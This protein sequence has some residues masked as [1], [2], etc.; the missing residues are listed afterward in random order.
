MGKHLSTFHVCGPRF[1]P[2]T[3]KIKYTYK[4]KK[5]RWHRVHCK[6]NILVK[7]CRLWWAPMILGEEQVN[8]GQ[9]LCHACVSIMSHS[10]EA[11]GILCGWS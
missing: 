3:P 5:G 6:S 10:G 9:G 7:S 8:E 2:R 1:A 4:I 11:T